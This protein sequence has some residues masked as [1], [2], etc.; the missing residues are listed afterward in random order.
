[1]SDDA[2]CC[3]GGLTVLFLAVGLAAIPM[4]RDQGPVERLGGR[5]GGV[6]EPTERT[7]GDR[8]AGRGAGGA[9]RAAARAEP[10]R[11]AARDARAPARLRGP[12]GRD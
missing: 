1:M 11:V 8:E 6:R 5:I 7:L 2:R 3:F 10:A 12:P 4:L 9:A